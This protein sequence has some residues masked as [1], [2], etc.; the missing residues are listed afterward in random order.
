[1]PF[2]DAIE[3]PELEE[4]VSIKGLLFGKP[5]RSAKPDQPAQ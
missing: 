5:A 2:G 3:W 4:Y 1:M